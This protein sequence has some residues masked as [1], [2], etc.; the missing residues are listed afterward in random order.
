MR[1]LIPLVCSVLVACPVAAR[2]AEAELTIVANIISYKDW[3]KM[4]NGQ[5]VD[6]TRR[7]SERK[8]ISSRSTGVVNGSGSTG[9]SH[10]RSSYNVQTGIDNPDTLARFKLMDI[11]ND[12]LV[13]KREYLIGTGTPVN[14]SDFHKHDRNRDGFLT[15]D[16]MNQSGL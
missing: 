7:K 2:A 13:T 5:F 12:N 6:I 10:K 15:L 3:K 8:R 9:I 16:E 14:N 1:I 4:D 11:N